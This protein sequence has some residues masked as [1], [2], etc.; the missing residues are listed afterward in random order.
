M[1]AATRAPGKAFGAPRAI[2]TSS[3]LAVPDDAVALGTRALVLLH[4]QQGTGA[5]L[6]A[7]SVHGRIRRPARAGRRD[8]GAHHRGRGRA[9]QP[10]PARSPST[11]SRRRR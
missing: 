3:T 10:T 7:S 6:V 5:T 2:A 8:D 1:R 4:A 9:A 11:P